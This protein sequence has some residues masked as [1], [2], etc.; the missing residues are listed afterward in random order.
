MSMLAPS[1]GIISRLAGALRAPAGKSIGAA[2]K[3]VGTSIVRGPITTAGGT[4]NAGF[5]MMGVP[6]GQRI[7]WIGDKASRLGGAATRGMYS[8]SIAP[9]ALI[10][11]P[12]IKAGGAALSAGL[13]TAKGVGRMAAA[14]GRYAAAPVG[15]NKLPRASLLL[16]AAAG[17]GA[18]GLAHSLGGA[19]NSKMRER[20]RTTMGLTQALHT[21]HR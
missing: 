12:L 2:A 19:V 6:R 14:Y 13:G 5:N 9:F 21:V 18:I 10:G 17:F 1:L 3:F 8:A 7:N 16:P 11:Y 20:D 15:K 4:I